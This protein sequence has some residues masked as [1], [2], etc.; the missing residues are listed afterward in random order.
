MKAVFVCDSLTP[1]RMRILEAYLHALDKFVGDVKLINM[2]LR[3]TIESAMPVGMDTIL[4]S[5]KNEF[6]EAGDW[7]AYIDR[8]HQFLV[9]NDID[10][11]FMYGCQMLQSKSF[12]QEKSIARDI[13]RMKKE[14]LLRTNFAT[15][16]TFYSRLQFVN[17]CSFTCDN[18]YHQMI[19][20]QEPDLSRVFDFKNYKELVDVQTASRKRV[21]MPYYEEYSFSD[22]QIDIDFSDRITAFKFGASA[23]TKDREFLIDMVKELK[24]KFGDEA[25]ITLMVKKQ[26]GKRKTKFVDQRQYV[27]DLRYTCSTLLV[28]AYDA[29]AFS[30]ARLVESAGKGCVP[31]VYAA[32]CLDSIRQLY[33]ELVELI[34]DELIAED[35]DGIFEL[36]EKS[37]QDDFR[38]R[39]CYDIQSCLAKQHVLD[40]QWLRDRWHKLPGL[41]D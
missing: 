3:S 12:N 5:I 4:F 35:V 7:P 30:L 31:I 40:I 14:V 36:V 9:D 25:D 6:D 32:C 18:V 23:T 19:D 17:A 15:M 16:K 27:Y 29:E 21:A 2:S 33:P 39:I 8:C 22:E 10:T 11:I 26:N 24:Q 13:F 34:E 28:P 37:K 41:S 38:K 20:P 1:G